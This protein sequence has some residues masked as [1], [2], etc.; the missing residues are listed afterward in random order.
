M[1]GLDWQRKIIRNYPGAARFTRSKNS[2]KY[3]L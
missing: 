2:Q 1:I 3:Y